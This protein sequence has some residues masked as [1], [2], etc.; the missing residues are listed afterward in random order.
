MGPADL[1]LLFTDRLEQADIPYLVTG[2]VASMAYG[3]PRLTHDIDLIIE[4]RREDALRLIGAFPEEEFYCP[5]REVIEAE[6]SRRTRG[7]FNVIHHATGYKAD[8]YL[9]GADGLHRW[10]LA[11]RV[12]LQVGDRPLWVAPPE[13]VIVRKL[14]YYREGRSEKHLRDIAG[15]LEVSGERID[16]DEVA[17]RVRDLGLEPE[18]E[19]AKAYREA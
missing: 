7:R 13:Y 18:W 6:A 12:C 2:S 15:M 17:A 16:R 11:R 3:E 4:L 10:A 19:A 8:L 1:F 14:E 5:P 9:A